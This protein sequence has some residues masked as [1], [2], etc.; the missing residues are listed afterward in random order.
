LASMMPMPW[1]AAVPILLVLPVAAWCGTRWM[2]E[3]A[4]AAAVPATLRIA[5]RW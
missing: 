3:G 4:H 2:A 1:F 5:D